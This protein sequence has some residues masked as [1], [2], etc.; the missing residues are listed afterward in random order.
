MEYGLQFI[1]VNVKIIIA[2]ALNTGII[3]NCIILTT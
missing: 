2:L 1:E 3:L